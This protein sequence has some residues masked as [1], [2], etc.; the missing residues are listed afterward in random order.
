MLTILSLAD[1]KRRRAV[2]TIVP[3]D[4]HAERVTATRVKYRQFDER[5]IAGRTAW[6]VPC[7]H[8]MLP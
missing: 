7:H 1:E 6:F 4:A 3:R 5:E 2:L 8:V